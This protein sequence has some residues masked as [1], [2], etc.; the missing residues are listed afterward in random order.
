MQARVSIL[1]LLGGTLML[2][3]CAEQ[4]LLSYQGRQPQSALECDAAFQE[5]RRRGSYQPAPTTSAGALGAAIGK[6]IGTG[7]IKSAYE[8]CLARVAALSPQ[9]GYGAA[10]VTPVTGATP[11]YRAAVVTSTAPV[12]GSA[13]GCGRYSAPLMGGGGYCV[14][15]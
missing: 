1:G 12:S 15:P 14:H 7:M 11:D 13:P 8:Q 4:D 3:S 2:M 5:A 9:P 6:G 10:P